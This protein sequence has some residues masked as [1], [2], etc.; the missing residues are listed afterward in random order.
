MRRRCRAAAA[1]ERSLS[2]GRGTRSLNRR[3][4]V[5]SM[6]KVLCNRV[7]GEKKGPER[8]SVPNASRLPSP[9]RRSMDNR[10]GE[11]ASQI[12]Q[13]LQCSEG[14]VCFLKESDRNCFILSLIVL[15]KGFRCCT[16]DDQSACT[17]QWDLFSRRV[18]A[19]CTRDNFYN[20]ALQHV[21]LL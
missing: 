2:D 9:V 6:R 13:Q 7:I 19:G 21:R 8:L 18:W 20:H 11:L 15:T 17:G 16:W 4:S 12:P 14:S 3:S 1:G 5:A 10:G